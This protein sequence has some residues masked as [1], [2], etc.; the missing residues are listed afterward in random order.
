MSN[1]LEFLISIKKLPG[2]SET[3][4]LPI[5]QSANEAAAQACDVIAFKK[6]Q[7][8]FRFKRW[9]KHGATVICKFSAQV[10]QECIAT[11]DPVFGRIEDSIERQFLPEHSSDY[12]MPE[13]IDGEMILDPEAADLPDII[14]GDSINLWDILIEELILV[15]NPFPRSDSVEQNSDFLQDIPSNKTNEPTHRP[16]SDLKTLITE[17]KSNK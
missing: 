13:I 7:A 17:K 6:L 5:N 10:E 15:I 2:P 12:K 1:N 16:F 8:S 11:L 4:T 9:R 14:V 3:L